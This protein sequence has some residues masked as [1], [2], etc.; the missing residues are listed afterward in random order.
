MGQVRKTSRRSSADSMSLTVVGASRN[1]SDQR[2]LFRSCACM[3]P[4]QVTTLAT[5][6]NAPTVDGWSRSRS[7]RL[8]MRSAMTSFGVNVLADGV[9]IRRPLYG[10][11]RRPS[12]YWLPPGP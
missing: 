10:A 6:R 1:P 2:P 3:A 12:P 9:V 5:S 4:N 8:R 11:R 7:S